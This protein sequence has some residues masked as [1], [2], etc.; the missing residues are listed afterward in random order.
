MKY[1]RKSSSNHNLRQNSSSNFDEINDL[2]ENQGFQYSLNDSMDFYKDDGSKKKR[3]KR[4]YFMCDYCYTSPKFLFK[5][6]KLHVKCNCKKLDNLSISDFIAKYTT[7]D[8]NVIEEHLYC[9]PHKRKY[10][11]Y[12]YYCRANVC[13]DC[14]LD[15]MHK[16]HYPEKFLDDKI[17]DIINKIKK[18]IK[19]FRKDVSAGDTENRK[20]LNLILTLIKNYKEYPCH[21]LHKSIKVFLTYLEE[22]EIPKIETKIKIISKNQLYEE[23]M[24]ELSKYI[25]SIKI[26]GENFCDLKI[27]SK[28]DLS[29]LTKLSLIGNNITNID[30]L[31]N[32]NFA[33][34]KYLDLENNKIDDEHFKNFGKMKLKDIRYVNLFENK[35]KSP[36]IFESVTNFPTLKTFFIGKNLF[37]E[38]EIKNNMHKTYD[39]SH[40]KK[41]GLTGNFTD[42][43]IEFISNLKLDKLEI[44][45]I[46]RNNLTSLDCLKNIHCKQLVSFWA[47]T[48]NLTDYKGVLNL[49]YKKK[50]E[51]IVL[52]E[53]K[54]SNIDDLS[55]FIKQFPK[56]KLFN[57]SGNHIDL[58]DPKNIEIINKIKK[59][60]KKCK[61]YFKEENN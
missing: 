35:I 23:K 60:Y 40:I 33:K 50:I 20:I 51:E 56:L 28:L 59:K 21:N 18:K 1:K 22:L 57:I 2:Y 53:N 24:I 25:T 43:T 30:P 44:M 3:L 41:I 52:K 55:N 5:A 15:D 9:K 4:R 13:K 7:H 42:K 19:E 47:I 16:N 11:Y 8:R 36:T 29:N 45:Y 12:C 14:L 31:L 58:D 54:I 32:I 34:L 10:E 39:L 38:K 27:L 46:S 48:N 37:E 6:N 17:E 61:F 26:N 49:K